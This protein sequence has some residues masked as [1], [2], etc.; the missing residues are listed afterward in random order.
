MSRGLIIGTTA[1]AAVV[2][3]VVLA[4]A[5]IGGLTAVVASTVEATPSVDP[6]RIPP[7]ARELLPRITD[8]TARRCPE[9]P[10]VWVVAEVAAESD[11]NPHAFSRD[12]NGGA[13]GLYQFD[14][15]NWVAA[16]GQPWAS[17]PPPTDADVVDPVRH[18]DLA[19]PFVCGNLH[20]VT[21]HLRA[22]GK[23]TA[24][25]DA[26]LVCHIAGC[27]RVTASATG[28]PQAGEAGC[29]TRC[30]ELVGRYLDTVHR[31]L[32]T[33]TADPSI[34]IGDLP[35]PRPFVGPDGACTLP[36]PTSPGCLI[37]ATRHALDQ[38]LATFGPPR[39]SA[40]LHSVVCW[41]PHPQNPRS[42]HPLGRVRLLPHHRRPVSRRRSARERMAAR[43]MATRTR[44]RLARALPHLAGPHLERRLDRPGRLGAPLRRRWGVRPDRRD[45]RPL[46]PRPP[47]RG[48]TGRRRTPRPR[49]SC[50][51]LTERRR[52]A[53]RP[54]RPLVPRP[55]R[56][57]F[58]G[59]G[60]AGGRTPRCRV[61][62]RKLAEQCSAR[63]RAHQVRRRHEGA[64]VH[65][66]PA[67]RARTRTIPHHHPAV[68][69]V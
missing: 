63:R 44:G 23:P 66:R 4:L 52:S 47:Q 54:A 9:L 12:R 6:A 15:A 31:L 35:A 17:T 29:G 50:M 20:A 57:C 48:V 59:S 3:P 65:R 43:H 39:P 19:V 49:D 28:V 26:M 41:D 36:D 56:C 18:L 11:W 25:L 24:P 1:A 14:Q 7:L 5:L 2:G 64:A 51:S 69:N 38:V 46:R 33:Y 58:R 55:V 10:P 68:L 60:R 42:D 40:P 34:E 45:G 21:A 13:A 27:D 61:R 62:R 37:P 16:G 8:L 53:G 30:A 22:T 67:A 32:A